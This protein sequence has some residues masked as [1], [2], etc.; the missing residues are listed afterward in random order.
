MQ[1][2]EFFSFAEGTKIQNVEVFAGKG[3][4]TEYRNAQK[5]VDKYGG[6]LEDWQHVKGTGILSTSDGDIKAEVHW[7]QCEGIGKVDFFVKRWIE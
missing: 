7:S 1:S 6:K 5:Y 2:G 3:V 4:K